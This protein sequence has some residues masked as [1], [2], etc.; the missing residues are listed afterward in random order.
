M[1][2][3]EILKPWNRGG[4]LILPGSRV[5]TVAANDLI[6]RGIAKEIKK[7][8]RPKREQDVDASADGGS[9]SGSG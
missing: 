3:V 8:G 2:T 1:R 6:R 4:V 5:E 9:D 7:R